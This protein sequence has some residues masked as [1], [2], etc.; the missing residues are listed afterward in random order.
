LLRGAAPRRLRARHRLGDPGGRRV[1]AEQHQ[2]AAPTSAS[3]IT[4]W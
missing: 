4:I 1:I 2:P 3:A